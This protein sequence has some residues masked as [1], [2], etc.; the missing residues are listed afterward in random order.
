MDTRFNIRHCPAILAGLSFLYISI[1][2]SRAAAV[3]TG[4]ACVIDGNSWTIVLT[5][6][7]GASCL[8]AAEKDI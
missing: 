7:N 6:P 3:I 2:E 4:R 1:G 5:M 8:V